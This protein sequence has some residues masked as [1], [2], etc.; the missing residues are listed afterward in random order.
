[1]PSSVPK[2][3][4]P[5]ATAELIR[6]DQQLA[7]NNILF[8]I[9]CVDM[10]TL[11]KSMVCVFQCED[12]RG[13]RAIDQ[14][15][16]VVGMTNC[17]RNMIGYET[18][19]CVLQGIR[20]IISISI[21]LTGRDDMRPPWAVNCCIRESVTYLSK[22]VIHPEIKTMPADHRPQIKRPQSAH[23]DRSS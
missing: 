7:S 23:V 13:T 15:R 4:V 19:W 5:T 21:T 1:V 18:C 8:L 11:R 6:S 20:E 3:S 2:S 17:R 14:S 9:G 10:I 22:S 16:I 12:E